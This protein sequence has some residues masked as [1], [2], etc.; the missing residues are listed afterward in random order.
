MN[1]KFL[2]MAVVSLSLILLSV[3]LV[4][5]GYNE[6]LHAETIA[7]LCPSEDYDPNTALAGV[8]QT[9]LA[10]LLVLISLPAFI[11]SLIKL[12]SKH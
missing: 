1:K 10:M 4:V 8:G 11:G 7:N 9:T 6:H 5:V 2:V 12:G 3:W